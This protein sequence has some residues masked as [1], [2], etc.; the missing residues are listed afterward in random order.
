MGTR[1]RL[2]LRSRWGQAL[3]ALA[4]LAKI[5][6]FSQGLF[7]KSG[8]AG[9]V[10]VPEAW[11]MRKVAQIGEGKVFG[12]AE[13]VRRTAFGL[14]HLFPAKRVVARAVGEIGFATHGWRL[15]KK[16]SKTGELAKAGK[17]EMIAA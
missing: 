16:Q 15:A 9:P 8:A 7:R 17:A 3:F 6:R 2:R 12:S 1:P 13:F 14:G 11:L 5:A 10:P 4:N